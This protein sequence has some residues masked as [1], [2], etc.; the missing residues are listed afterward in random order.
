MMAAHNFQRHPGWGNTDSFCCSACEEE[1]RGIGGSVHPAGA[2]PFVR[3]AVCRPC[4]ERMMIDK[5]FR[6][7]VKAKARDF[8]E[9]ACAQRF[10]DVLGV[11]VRQLAEAIDAIGPDNAVTLD[12]VLDLAPGTADAAM[13]YVMF[14]KALTPRA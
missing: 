14:G 7:H 11:T 4:H 13:E 5:V 8:A 9:R 1:R 12:Q 10:A 3:M 6:Q 2:P